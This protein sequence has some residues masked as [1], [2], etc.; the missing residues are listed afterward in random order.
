MNNMSFDTEARNRH[1]RRDSMF[2]KWCSSIQMF[3]S[4]RTQR[5]QYLP[6]NNFQSTKKF[7]RYN[8]PDPRDNKE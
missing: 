4:R 3:A 1:W 8:E 7:N 2:K 6:Q 5:D